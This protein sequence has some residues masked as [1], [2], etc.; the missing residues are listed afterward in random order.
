MIID[1]GQNRHKYV[2]DKDCFLLIG[3]IASTTTDFLCRVSG[4][5]KDLKRHLA[6]NNDFR[7]AIHVQAAEEDET[8]QGVNDTHRVDRNYPLNI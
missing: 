2:L 1:P 8:F 3:I 5:D 4:D 7:R 6:S